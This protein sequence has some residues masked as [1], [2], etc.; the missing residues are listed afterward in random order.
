MRAANVE[1][2]GAAGHAGHGRTRHCDVLVVGGGVAGVVAALRAQAAG[3]QVVLARRGWGA[4]ALTSGAWEV[5]WQPAVGGLEGPAASI[6]QHLADIVAHRGRHPY[7][8]MGRAAAAAAL[9]E[10][11]GLLSAALAH[12]PA[13]PVDLPAWDLAAAHGWFAAT[14]GLW[15]PA[16]ATVAGG[17]A[18]PMS[19]TWG[20]W[21]VPHS[22]HLRAV[23][24][25]AGLEAG[26][27]PPAGQ[28]PSGWR[29]VTASVP[30]S[31]PHAMARA[32]EDEAVLAAAV[33]ALRPQ[34]A[35]LAGLMTPPILGVDQHLGVRAKLEAALGLPVREMVAHLPSVPGL[36]LQRALD[37]VV[38]ASGV[39]Q[40]GAVRAVHRRG[41][42]AEGATLEDGQRWAAAAVVLATG[43]FAGGGIAT[44]RRPREQLLG[45][46]VVSDI[47]RLE[48]ENLYNTVRQSPVE[49]HPL[50]TAGVRVNPG[51]QALDD[52]GSPLHNV[53]AAGM[54]LGGFASRFCRCADG[55]AVATGNAAGAAA[56]Q[57]VGKTW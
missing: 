10:G 13:S 7:G 34:L 12:L 53:F 37:L 19:G 25:I 24:A 26:P 11:H 32:M 35:G 1:H 55:V 2:A 44:S 22:P 38:A 4:S 33:A 20:V 52:G 42:S 57:V 46:P 23:R 40:V 15:V 28:A 47:G 56:A 18:G 43:K 8:V 39:G 27:L 17:S 49:S 41:A 45:L 9:S 16:A 5:A 14:T 31:M 51:L 36:R 29:P 6:G 48:G 30:G 21:E 3:A 54:V 50:L